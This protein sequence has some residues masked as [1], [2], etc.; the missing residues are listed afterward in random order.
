MSNP[1]SVL[2]RQLHFRDIT[3]VETRLS[4]QVHLAASGS[5]IKE[6]VNCTISCTMFVPVIYL[7]VELTCSRSPKISIQRGWKALKLS[8]ETC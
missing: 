2:R 4:Y 7:L 3:F 1:R 6:K 8:I 5:I